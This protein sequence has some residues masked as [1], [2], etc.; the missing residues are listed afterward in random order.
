VLLLLRLHWG[1]CFQIS[2]R[3]GRRR[4]SIWGLVECGRQCLRPPPWHSAAAGSRD[5]QLVG[6]GGKAGGGPGGGGLGPVPYFSV[7]LL[8]LGRK[9]GWTDD[10]DLVCSRRDLGW[11]HGALGSEACETLGSVTWGRPWK[12]PPPAGWLQNLQPGQ[13]GGLHVPQKAGGGQW[14]QTFSHLSRF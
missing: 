3:P 7:A 6:V 1:R 8:V 5:A 13:I 4:A 11:L 12:I 2:T 10:S 9:R 14:A